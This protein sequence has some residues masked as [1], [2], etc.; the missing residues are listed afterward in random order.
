MAEWQYSSTH[1]HRMKVSYHI[2][3]PAVLTTKR[4]PN[5]D[6]IRQLRPKADLYAVAN[7]IP[8]RFCNRTN[9]HL[10]LC[11]SHYRLQTELPRHL[12]RNWV[13]D[14][15]RS[16]SALMARPKGKSPENRTV[17]LRQMLSQHVV[18][19]EKQTVGNL[20]F[21]FLILSFRRVLYVVCFPSGNSQASEF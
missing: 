9:G 14:W 20:M 13:E 15:K 2:H 21:L 8:L 11:P 17:A 4:F 12:L 1:E 16:F 10:S 5:T 6:V 3:V 7:R 19:W 18:R